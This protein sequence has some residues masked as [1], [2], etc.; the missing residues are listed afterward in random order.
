M[1]AI[2]S[3]WIT[4]VPG[5]YVDLPL[6]TF[7]AA[8][9]IGGWFEQGT[10]IPGSA[11]WRLPSA[12]YQNPQSD[13]FPIAREQRAGNYIDAALAKDQNTGKNAYPSAYN[14]YSTKAHSDIRAGEEGVGLKG[15]DDKAVK[16]ADGLRGW[17]DDG[18]KRADF[19]AGVEKMGGSPYGKDVAAGLANLLAPNPTGEV[20]KAGAEAAAAL[21]TKDEM[22]S[23]QTAN[24]ILNK[25]I[26]K[27]GGESVVRSILDR[28][29]AH[30]S[31]KG[32]P[33]K[34]RGDYVNAMQEKEK[35]YT[36]QQANAIYDHLMAGKDP[37]EQRE[38]MSKLGSVKADKLDDAE[39]KKQQELNARA[40][41]LSALGVENKD[42]L[43]KMIKVYES[44][45][46]EE[47]L[48]AVKADVRNKRVPQPPATAQAA[49]PAAAPG[50]G[51]RPQGRPRRHADAGPLE[52]GSELAL[53]G[54]KEFLKLS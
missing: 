50:P 40:E 41:V 29:W 2:T 47:F 38:F 17:I 25:L 7:G 53:L 39:N 1:F 13:S 36:S 3:S 9:T 49:P 15:Q 54:A 44:K 28:A 18:D 11:N 48:D 52:R 43:E 8:S 33:T 12:P 6:S 22:P 37:S 26:E 31:A 45:S 10:Y 21:L 51:A 30:V 46:Y 19:A 35:G 14:A 32:I 20:S 23:E 27:L 4:T 42:D 5:L 34:G 16:I 24:K